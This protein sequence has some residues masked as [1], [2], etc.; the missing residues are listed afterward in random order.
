[1]GAN[2]TISANG[3]NDTVFGV[4]GTGI[5]SGAKSTN[6]VFA[7]LGGSNV[8][9]VG[10][11]AGGGSPTVFGS[12]GA[13][14]G[15]DT[16]FGG[17]GA[18]LVATGESNDTIFA[19]TAAGQTIFGG[20][21]NSG[22]GANVIHGGTA[23]LEIAVGASKDTIFAGSGNDSIYIGNGNFADDQ[24]ING[25]TGPLR[26]QF[27]GGAGSATVVGGAGAVTVFGIGTRISRGS[28]DQPAAFWMPLATSARLAAITPPHRPPTTHCSA[29]Q[30]MSASRVVL[31]TISWWPASIPAVSVARVRLSVAR[32]CPVEQGPTPS[33][34]PADW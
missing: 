13:A 16:I 24:L 6:L 26:V 7:N 4:S 1:M 5:I 17:A 23:D 14:V 21:A 25:G 34:S 8:V 29:S 12:F 28:A 18:L 22:N 27:I 3:T 10:G 32:P 9:S 31:V 33:Y 2:D 19:G 11:A 15:S 20:Y 30:A